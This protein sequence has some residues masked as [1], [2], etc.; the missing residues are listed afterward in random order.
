VHLSKGENPSLPSASLLYWKTRDQS[1]RVAQCEEIDASSSY[2]FNK[3]GLH[4]TLGSLKSNKPSS[5][6][7]HLD[8]L[9]LYTFY[10]SFVE[11]SAAPEFEF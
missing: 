11:L 3:I 6:S 1:L 4:H 8:T 5:E 2:I 9:F 10:A 7:Q